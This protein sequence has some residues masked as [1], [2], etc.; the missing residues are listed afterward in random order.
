MST[1]QADHGPGL[2]AI[3]DLHAG[4]DGNL[5]AIDRLRPRTDGDWLVVA[6]DVADRFGTIVD[7]LDRL[8][9]RFARVVWT[10]GNH[11]LWTP[12]GDPVQARGAERYGALVDAL[13]RHDVTTP[14]DDW[15]VWTSGAGPVTI[16]P[17]HLLFDYSFRDTTGLSRREAV[18]EAR[19]S[20]VMSSDEVYLHPDPFESRDAWS[21]ALVDA[22]RRRLDA[23]PDG[24]RT[25]LVNHYPLERGPL[26]RIRRA[27][28][29]MWAGTTATAGWAVRYRAE[30]VVYGH[31]HI[32][33]T[34]VIEGVPHHEVSLGYPRE[35]GHEWSRPRR[36]LRLLEPGG[37]DIVVTPS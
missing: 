36:A 23:L 18:A 14:D 9:D 28:I 26:A 19:R 8:R 16:V 20:G 37:A 21:R 25:V 35:R 22:A 2:Y 29:G 27:Q 5:D 32:P 34:D 1:H 31:L 12:P 33:V 10:P 15:P 13:R 11:D 7:T 24:V 3:S 17:L 6:G 4:F 30:A